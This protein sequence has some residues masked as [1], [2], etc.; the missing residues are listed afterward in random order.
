MK[1]M[2]KFGHNLIRLIHIIINSHPIFIKLDHKK[3]DFKF[4]F[5][6]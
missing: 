5:I 4:Y 2:S 3:V 6:F 1:Q